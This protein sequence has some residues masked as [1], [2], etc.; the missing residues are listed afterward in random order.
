MHRAYDDLAA[1]HE[2]CVQESV[3]YAGLVGATA[4]C[5][6][7]DAVEDAVIRCVLFSSG[8]DYM[9]RG[10]VGVI[11]YYITPQ[12]GGT[13]SHPCTLSGYLASELVLLISTGTCP[14]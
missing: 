2:V 1:A 12:I 7:T 9:H 11:S 5:L 10:R 6:A 8:S 14:S 4:Q 13:T 3:A